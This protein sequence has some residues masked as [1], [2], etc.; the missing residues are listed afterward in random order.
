[1]IEGVWASDR[2]AGVMRQ[3]RRCKAEQDNGLINPA[4]PQVQRERLLSQSQRLCSEEVTEGSAQTMKV[5]T[6]HRY[7]NV[8]LLHGSHC[9]A[10]SNA[11]CKG[12]FW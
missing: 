2:S 12:K 8:A 11:I 1:M 4:T 10:T 9:S 5:H 7:I 3:V 6:G